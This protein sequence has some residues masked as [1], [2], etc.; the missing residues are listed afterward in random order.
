[1]PKMVGEFMK[2]NQEDINML[3]LGKKIRKMVMADNKHLLLSTK[4]IL[5]AIKKK[6][7]VSLQKMELDMKSLGKMIKKMGLGKE[8]KRMDN[9]SKYTISM[10]LNQLQKIIV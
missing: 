10:E 2:I 1:M 4:V 9:R 6:D 8:L 3:D 7:L 5:L